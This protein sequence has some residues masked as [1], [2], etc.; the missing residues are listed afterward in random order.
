MNK[1]EQELKNNNF[2]CS[3]CT[4]CDRLVWPPNDFCNKCFGNVIWH[5]VS[6]SAKIVE[7]SSKDKELFCL[8]E[9]EEGIKVMGRVESASELHVG[10]S[11]L[12]SRCDYDGKEIFVFRPVLQE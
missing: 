8:V 7:F 12:L 1:F 2:L 5:P 10:Q 11:L 3:Q 6:R 4:K 9:F